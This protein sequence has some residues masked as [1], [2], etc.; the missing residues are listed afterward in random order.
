MLGEPSP[1]TTFI[2]LQNAPPRVIEAPEMPRPSPLFP[3]TLP[4]TCKFQCFLLIQ[5][6]TQNKLISVVV[7]SLGKLCRSIGY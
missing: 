4:L 5:C 7:C 1:E 2:G 6:A 3:L